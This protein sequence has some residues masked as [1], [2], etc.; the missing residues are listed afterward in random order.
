MFRYMKSLVFIGLLLLSLG[1]ATALGTKY[2]IETKANNAAQSFISNHISDGMQDEEKILEISKAVYLT[3]LS[4]QKSGYIP[5]LFRLQPYLAHE[6]IPEIIRVKI[7]AIEAIYMEGMCDSASRRLNFILDIAGYPSKQFNIVSSKTGHSISKSTLPSG[8][9]ILIDSYHGVMSAWQGKLIGPKKTMD[10]MN[11]GVP[12][13]DVWR[14]L[15]PKADL[16]FYQNFNKHS[17]AEEGQ[18]LRIEVDVDM[19]DSK[20]M[21]FGEIDGSSI[22][23]EKSFNRNDWAPYWTYIGHRYDRGFER[24]LNFHQKTRVTFFL[25]RDV[26]EGFITS[27]IPPKKIQGN[28]IIYEIEKGRSLHFRDGLA[29]RDWLRLKSSQPV[30]KIIFEMID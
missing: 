20:E 13:S 25:T 23:L 11:D 17:I 7:G 18:P 6:L 3:N 24:I 9:D 19:E 21:S 12:A 10:L 14:T 8:S 2:I 22:D 27:Q 28:L 1:F 4:S 26:N 5:F 30:D 16:T 29:K 15:G